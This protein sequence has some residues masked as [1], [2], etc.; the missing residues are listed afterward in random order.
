M[1]FAVA[2]LHWRTIR[3]STGT[4]SS[5]IENGGVGYSIGNHFTL[6]LWPSIQ[7]TATIMK[8]GEYWYFIPS[9]EINSSD[10]GVLH[11]ND[12]WGQEQ[13]AEVQNDF[14]PIPIGITATLE[15]Y[16]Y[17]YEPEPT[18]EPIVISSHPQE[19]C[20]SIDFLPHPS[21]FVQGLWTKRHFYHKIFFCIS[22]IT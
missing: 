1:K 13:T 10:T 16:E 18:F 20:P 9:R 2:S 6:T 8:T 3:L 19:S 12:F 7:E 17:V 15:D 5:V 22:N 11:G 21:L 14:E 4:L